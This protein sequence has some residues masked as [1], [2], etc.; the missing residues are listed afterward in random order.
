MKVAIFLD[1]TGTY[2]GGATNT[3]LNQAILMNQ[4]YDVTVIIP[5]DV[6]GAFCEV[7]LEKCKA[8]IL[9]YFFLEYSSAYKIMDLNFMQFDREVLAIEEYLRNQDFGLIHYAQL[10]LAVE[11]A[12][13][14]LHIPTIMN[15]YSLEE[16][17]F[18][19][20]VRDIYPQ[21]IS[22]DS[23]LWCSKWGEYTGS[24]TN[25]IRVFARKY[26]VPKSIDE[27]NI[28]LGIIGYVCD[29]KNQLV[30]IQAIQKFSNIKLYVLGTEQTD[31]AEQCRQYVQSNGLGEQVIFRGFCED[32]EKELGELDAVLCTSK[33]ESFPS[34]IV[35]AMSVQLPI[36]STPVA[37]VPE[38][39]NND[40]AYISRGYCVED[41]CDAIQRYLD[42]VRSGNIDIVKAN[43]K[44]TYDT[45]FSEEVVRQSLTEL[46]AQVI[47]CY[48]SNK[49]TIKDIE[50]EIYIEKQWYE[51]LKSMDLCDEDF[52]AIAQRLSYYIE[53][54]QKINGKKCYIWGAGKWGTRAKAILDLLCSETQL[55]AYIDKKRVKQ[56]NGYKV[57]P[58]S[59]I[60]FDQDSCILL[61]YV[62]EKKNTLAFLDNKNCKLMKQVFMII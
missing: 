3:L 48:D 41:I 55:I 6:N 31:Y 4:V 57:I 38:V 33:R 8:N 12:A 21:Y 60:E 11:Y 34:S 24:R 54:S 15:I 23:V 43:E 61:A 2:F 47:D 14:K 20:P 58:P 52:Y 5:K 44:K 28:K 26:S 32:M 35:E 59:E 17:E 18:D 50:E 42:D 9:Q 10:S 36:I 1:S 22:S 45:I 53:I 49:A 46:Y 27:K 30:A 39:L 13:R 51:K 25:C 37:G 56:K 40:N 29:Y 62:G 19:L 7:S 16:W